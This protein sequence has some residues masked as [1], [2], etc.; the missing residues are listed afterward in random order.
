MSEKNFLVKSSPHFRDRDS[1]PKIMYAVVISLAP[2]L[3]A[4][5]YY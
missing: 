3:F 2:A 4:S 5:I 1:V